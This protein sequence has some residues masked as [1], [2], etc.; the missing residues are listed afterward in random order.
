[1]KKSIILCL[2]AFI[3]AIIAYSDDLSLIAVNKLPTDAEF[4]QNFK[5]IQAVSVYVDHYE[6]KWDYPLSKDTI[7]KQLIS[8]SSYIDERISKDPSNPEL[9][10]LKVVLIKYLYNLDSPDADT[11]FDSFIDQA[12][13]DFPTDPRFPWFYGDFLSSAGRPVEAISQFRKLLSAHDSAETLPADFWEDYGKACYLAMMPKNAIAAFQKAADL[14]KIP[15][16]SY[17]IA[18]AAMELIKT[19]D[20]NGT[21]SNKDAW[22]IIKSGET[23]Y[24]MSQLFGI[25]MPIKDNWNIKLFDV[26]NRK[27]AVVLSPP[28]LK[29]K[30]G[31]EIG[32]NIVI[33]INFDDINNE[34][35]IK[36]YLRKGMKQVANQ[37]NAGLPMTQFE[38]IDKETYPQIG[39]AHGYMTFLSLDPS[40]ESGLKLEMPQQVP[41][42]SEGPYFSLNETYDRLD[43]QVHIGII[44]DSCEEVFN[45]SKAI[46]DAILSGAVFE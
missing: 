20:S 26:T 18:T 36:Q 2:F 28:K 29:S 34:A 39:G 1:M 45:E 35:F 31:K 11:N 8:I 40:P 38:W 37:T 3:V 43:H 30:T 41:K 19:P 32:I 42:D 23:F 21:F 5:T 12:T 33:V 27:S 13:T 44:L 7:E 16:N 22:K 24:L 15:V 14:R 46:Y 17:K 25:R 10:L 4:I 6:T 9:R